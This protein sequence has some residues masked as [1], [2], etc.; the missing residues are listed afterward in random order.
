[1]DINVIHD[2]RRADR[3]ELL[4]EVIQEHGVKIQ[5]W[6]AQFYAPASFVG[7][8]R[9]HRQ[10]VR[11]AK[12]RGL[13]MVCIAEDDFYF[14]APGAWEYY[15]A[16][17]PAQF[18]LYLSMVYAGHIQEDGTVP[19]FTALTLYIVSERFYDTFLAIPE[20]GHLDRMLSVERPRHGN[21]FVVCQPF[22]AQQ[23]DGYSDQKRAYAT[24]GHYL[25]GKTLFGF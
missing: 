7:V 17:I 20:F 24:Y 18:D 8:S 10:I 9:A 3:Y 11:W 16:N 13:P 12:E 19:D 14:T 22:I 15:L 21:K 6:P 4:Q 5:W 1:M 23:R 25:E 2:I